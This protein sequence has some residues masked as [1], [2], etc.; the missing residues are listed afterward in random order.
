MNHEPHLK[1]K[2]Q[3][4]FK[5]GRKCISYVRSLMKVHTFFISFKMV[6]QIFQLSE[7]NPFLDTNI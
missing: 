3:L 4:D 7:G 1:R 2:L 5:I 6:F